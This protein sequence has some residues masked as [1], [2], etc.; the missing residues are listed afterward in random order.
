MVVLVGYN[1]GPDDRQ[2]RNRLKQD[3]LGCSGYFLTM[4]SMYIL[5]SWFMKLKRL[6]YGPQLFHRWKICL[7]LGRKGCS[8][9]HKGDL[10]F[11]F[12]KHYCTFLLLL[13]NFRW[14]KMQAIIVIEIWRRRTEMEVRAWG[15]FVM[16]WVSPS[17][18]YPISYIPKNK[19]VL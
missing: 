14:L 3:M 19:L 6:L 12:R 5:H 11:T 1:R 15:C 4:P 2:L 9:N 16:P 18:C 7:R 13:L 8:N 10:S 17:I